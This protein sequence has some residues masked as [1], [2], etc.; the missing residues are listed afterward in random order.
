[1]L[2]CGTRG[3]MHLAWY[4]LPV[5]AKAFV[6]YV[7]LDARASDSQKALG[8]V[9]AKPSRMTREI[10]VCS[11]DLCNGRFR[12][13]DLAPNNSSAT[14]LSPPDAFMRVV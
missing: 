7:D 14:D 8:R 2:R 6:W 9:E 10:G 4:H 13:D 12:Y 5:Y 3:Q 1:M 11:R